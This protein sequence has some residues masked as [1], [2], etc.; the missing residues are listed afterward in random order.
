M[1][2]SRS[3]EMVLNGAETDVVLEALDRHEPDATDASDEEM[4]RLNSKFDRGVDATENVGVELTRG[5]A[6]VVLSAL[7]EYGVLADERES[8]RAAALRERI[9]EEFGLED[10]RPEGAETMDDERYSGGT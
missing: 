3:E 8:E 9:A 1:N 5:D 10:D 4:E 2:D 7:N 6:T